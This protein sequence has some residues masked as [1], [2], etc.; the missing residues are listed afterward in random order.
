M[1]KVEKEYK[2]LP[3]YAKQ[4]LDDPKLTDEDREKIQSDLDSYK[5]RYDGILQLVTE[6]EQE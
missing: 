2:D 6:R 1:K 4:I 3:E 5:I